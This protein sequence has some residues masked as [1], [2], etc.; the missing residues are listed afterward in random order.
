MP[1]L[2]ASGADQAILWPFDGVK[3]AVG[4]LPLQ[5][6]WSVAASVN[7]AQHADRR[8]LA[9]TVAQAVPISPAAPAFLTLSLWI[10]CRLW[11]PF[12]LCLASPASAARQRTAAP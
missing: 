2:A 12:A 3:G 1:S 10:L 4:R 11:N 5:L 8:L 9:V 6:R 7:A